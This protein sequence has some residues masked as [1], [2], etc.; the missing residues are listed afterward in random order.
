[1]YDVLFFSILATIVMILLAY[2]NKRLVFPVFII[3]L[4]FLAYLVCFKSGRTNLGGI[5]IKLPLP[6]LQAIQS[7]HYGLTT[8]RSVLNIILFIPFGY[9]LP[10]IFSLYR[11]RKNG[12]NNI[13][14][15]PGKSFG[16]RWWFVVGMGFLTSLVIE[17]SQLIFHFG[18]FELDDLVKNTMGAGIGYAIWRTLERSGRKDANNH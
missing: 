15:N 18:V 7:H 12:M 8:N 1:M 17:T 2:Y 4:F 13:Q 6:F 9:L 11:H 5:S 10:T 14:H 3:Y 16:T